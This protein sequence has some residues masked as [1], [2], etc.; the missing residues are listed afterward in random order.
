MD[1]WEAL[2]EQKRAIAEFMKER[3]GGL[4]EQLA[5]K[6]DTE[7]LPDVLKSIDKE[8]TV[9]REEKKQAIRHELA[10]RGEAVPFWEEDRSQARRG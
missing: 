5:A 10:K 9:K 3:L 7:Y 2:R 1:Q 4:L 8:S 6:I